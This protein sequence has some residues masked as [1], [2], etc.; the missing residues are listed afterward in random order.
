[1][2]HPALANPN[3]LF[4]FGSGAR[5]TVF[6]KPLLDEIDPPRPN[7]SAGD[8][9]YYS[10]F[11]DPTQ[12]F[13]RN[14]RYDFGFSGAR[15][16]IGRYCAFAHDTTFIMSDANHAIAGPSTYPFPVFGGAWSS[17]IEPR[18]YPAVN[19]GSIQVGHDVWCG[20]KSVIMPGVKIGSGAIVAACA[21]VSRDVP[22]YA[23]V[24]GNPARVVKMRFE[25]HDVARLLQIAWWDW[26][27]DRV[28]RAV[29]VLVKGSVDELAEVTR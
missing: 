13:I 29:P 12:F 7:L 19:K 2:P 5:H 21:V 24:A 8:F 9:S 11:D 1:M 23:M 3:T 20:Y 10:D 28:A 18:D 26:P 15:L 27:A 17:E 25:P 6:L 16:D 4:P 14:V 22:P